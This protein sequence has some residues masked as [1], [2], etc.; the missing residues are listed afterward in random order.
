MRFSVAPSCDLTN[1][2]PRLYLS[3]AASLCLLSRPESIEEVPGSDI[4]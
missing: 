1:V 4:G 2:V 3:D